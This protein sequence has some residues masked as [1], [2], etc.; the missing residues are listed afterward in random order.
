MTDI[1]VVTDWVATANAVRGTLEEQAA[2]S[3]EARTATKEAVE[4][5]RRSGLFTLL[6]PRELGGP[7]VD[8]ATFTDTLAALSY[9]DGSLGWTVLANATNTAF[10]AAFLGDEAVADMFGSGPV[11]VAAQLSPRG[12]IVSAGDGWKLSGQYSFGS[13]SGH[14]AWIGGGAI[15]L[16]GGQ[17]AM[18][19]NG[20]PRIR[21][22]YVP[23]DQVTF[24]DGWHVMGL[25]GTGSYDYHILD[26][27][28]PDAY[29][30]P[31]LGPPRRGGPVYRLRVPIIGTAGHAGW[32]LGAARRALDEALSASGR[33]FMRGLTP[34]G[35]MEGYLTELGELDAALRSAR[36]YVLE[37]FAE[38]E[39]FIQHADAPSEELSARVQQAITQCTRVAVHVVRKSFEWS[40]VSA[41]RNGVLERA[42]RDIHVA[43][44]HVTQTRASFAN[45]TR[46]AI[47]E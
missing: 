22:C 27:L 39:A 5:L 29:T 25:A 45:V 41:I 38:A 7:E 40:G 47:A 43:A 4:A 46:V 35:Q 33:P 37:V 15:E 32:A 44:Q 14:A 23:R 20:F 13:G 9:A 31:L 42:F 11:E 16:D 21:G 2:G 17:P 24:K 28:V 6:I 1:D 10:A 34:V 3:E 18:A 30:F 19:P 12:T 36:S 26:R 8:L